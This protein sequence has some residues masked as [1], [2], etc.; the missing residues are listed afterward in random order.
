[1][2]RTVTGSFDAAAA[3]PPALELLGPHELLLA[4][5]D[6]HA[7]TNDAGAA[8]WDEA[9]EVTL[10]SLAA[11]RAA[12]H[13]YRWS[14]MLPSA[15]ETQRELEQAAAGGAGSVG[16]PVPNPA[17]PAL[18]L[19]APGATP[20]YRT[21][22]HT[23]AERME[24]RG[25]SVITGALPALL[26]QSPS[27]PPSAEAVEKAGRMLGHRLRFGL[28]LVAA[29]AAVASEQEEEGGETAAALQD[30]A[31]RV[32]VGFIGLLELLP[33]TEA[34]DAPL[35]AAAALASAE[36][37]GGAPVFITTQDAFGRL[38]PNVA[39][40]D[41]AIEALTVQGSVPPAAVVL[42]RL[43]P[44]PALEG[45]YVALLRRGV[46]LAFTFQGGVF[47]SLVPVAAVVD[48]N[49]AAAE[50]A[51]AAGATR[52]FPSDGD[53]A[54]LV[55]RLCRQGFGAQLLLSPGVACRIQLSKYGGHGYGH[56]RQ[57]V[58]PQL[59]RRGVGEADVRAMLR[60][61]I[62]RLLGW[63]TPPPP[64]ERPV[65][66][67]TCSWCGKAFELRENEYFH[68]FSFVYCRS[69]CLSKH[70]DTGWKPLEP[71]L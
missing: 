18:V 12:P 33:G 51:A 42:C 41:A 45:Q 3:A 25:V 54:A 57:G 47:Y 26:P 39:R 17:A 10:T 27:S 49:E 29:A 31:R 56:V 46:T 30:Q 28:P 65:E 15:E 23:L 8:S 5:P 37:G 70:G 63:W 68:K 19:H 38:A 61:N 48:G 67:G 24:A 59:R 35:L 11:I 64:V 1:M 9:T 50:M 53:G 60:E 69:K 66:M 14:V 32:G 4:S 16:A 71:K 22:L 36:A 52:D 40:L 6:S 13:R 44:D 43:P 55:A 20:Q 7:C 2:I 34:M 58:V 62:V 21:P